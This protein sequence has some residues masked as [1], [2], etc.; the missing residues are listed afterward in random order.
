M[1]KILNALQTSVENHLAETG[2]APA[3]FGRR[4]LNDPRFVFDLRARKRD[5]HT[6]TVDRVYHYIDTHPAGKAQ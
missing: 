2:T 4:V 6:G 3:T 1:K 5:F